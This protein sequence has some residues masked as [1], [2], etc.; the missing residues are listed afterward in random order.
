MRE[1]TEA[2][3]SGKVSKLAVPLEPEERGAEKEKVVARVD[4]TKTKTRERQT[5]FLGVYCSAISSALKHSLLKKRDSVES[6]N[7]L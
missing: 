3:Q 4:I 7:T 5:S 1:L 6:R 2:Q